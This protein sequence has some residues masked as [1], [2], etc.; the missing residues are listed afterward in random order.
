MA[1]TQ[2]DVKTEHIPQPGERGTPEYD[3]KMAAI[4]EK[5][6]MTTPNGSGDEKLLAGKFKSQDELLKGIGEL[7][8]DF[9]RYYRYLESKR[10]KGGAEGD[11]AGD[12]GD[13]PGT[14][15]EGAEKKPGMDALKIEETQTEAQNVLQKAGLDINKY[16]DEFTKNGELSAESYEQL[17][18]AGFPKEMVDAYIEGQKAI[19]SRL[20]NSLYER[21]GGE[22]QYSNMVAW[23]AKGGLSKN[24]IQAF[25][26]TFESGN[27]DTVL[28]AIDGLRA[29]FEKKF[30]NEPSLLDGVGDGGQPGYASWEEML[31]DQANPKY[32]E[33]PAF[34]A[35]VQKK[36]RSL[37]R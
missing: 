32:R 16:N 7:G 6:D 5:P 26:A 2:V 10:G 23:A 24:E 28:L 1:V 11:P 35:M 4:G 19:A 34:R 14:S 17:T 25:N 12:G 8:G 29:K 18:K 33:D 21:A 27:T 30:G 13:P 20:M 37:M 36:A 3:A 9:E 22:K 15:T 31:A